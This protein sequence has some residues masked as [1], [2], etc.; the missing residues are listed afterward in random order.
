MS[1]RDS[2]PLLLPA[3]VDCP[4][5]GVLTDIVFRAPDGVFELEDLTD[6]PVME[7]KGYCGHTYT[8][9]YGGWVAHEDA[10]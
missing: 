1:D 4:E 8:V 3:T 9:Q 10:G 5:C 2:H 7:V 6:P